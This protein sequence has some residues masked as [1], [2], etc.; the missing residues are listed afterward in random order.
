MSDDFEIALLRQKFD[1][2]LNPD[3]PNRDKILD[4]FA[5]HVFQSQKH[6]MQLQE[7]FMN[8][9]TGDKD[10]VEEFKLM[11]TAVMLLT[12]G[13][14]PSKVKERINAVLDLADEV[15]ELGRKHQQE[16]DYTGIPDIG[17]AP[18][19]E[20]VFCRLE[21]IYDWRE[22]N[23]VTN[24]PE[25]ELMRLPKDINVKVLCKGESFWV[26]IL[27]QMHDAQYLCEVNNELV[28]SDLHG[29]KLGDRILVHIRSIMEISW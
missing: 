14:S 18:S 3:Y 1:E 23:G 12:T 28:R 27:E 17:I 24:L 6:T 7:K 25:S 29:L 8:L 16:D 4:A 5:F 2:I 26:K 13:V 20:V 22:K 11:I 19:S 10:K 21:D 9:Y 15:E